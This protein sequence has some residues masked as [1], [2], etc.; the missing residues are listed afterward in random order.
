MQ[1]IIIVGDIDVDKVEAAVKRI[2]AD[3]PAPV[4]PAKREYTEVADNDKPLVSIATDKEASNMVLSIFYKHDKMP[5]EL[6]ATAAGLM[7][8]YMENVV[9]TMIN[10]RMSTAETGNTISLLTDRLQ[11]LPLRW[12]AC[13]VP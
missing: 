1:G 11:D 3:I 2:F 4:N 10:E 12:P 8:D 5:K 7:K 6:Y 9:E 13:E